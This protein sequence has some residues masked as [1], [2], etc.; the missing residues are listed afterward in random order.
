MAISVHTLLYVWNFTCKV[1]SVL[2]AKLA[3]RAEA[4]P[5]APHLPEF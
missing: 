4:M 1:I 3:L 5:F 2:F